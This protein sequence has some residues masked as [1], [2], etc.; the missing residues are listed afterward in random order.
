[1]LVFVLRRQ[2]R[3]AAVIATG[4]AGAVC[5]AFVVYLRQPPEAQSGL[6]ALLSYHSRRPIVTPAVIGSLV[7]G[8]SFGLWI[9]H[10]KCREPLAFLA[11]GCLLLPLLLSNQQIVTDVMISARDW[12]RDVSY[13]LLVFGFLTAASLIFPSRVRSQAFARVAWIAA[14]GCTLIVVRSQFN[15]FRMW[16]KTNLQ[17][18]AIV[19]ALGSVEA[20]LLTEARL[21]FSNAGISQLIQVRMDDRVNVPLTFYKVA[22]RLVPNMAPDARLADP[23]SYENLVFEH[24]LRTGASPERAEDV[25]RAEIRQRAGTFVNYLFSLR[26]ASYPASDNRAFRQVELERS[27]GPIIARYGDYLRLENRRDVLDRPGLLISMESPAEL[28]P[29]PWIRNQFVASGEA[30]GVT[31]YVYRQSAL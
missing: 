11:L 9:L 24:W 15:A 12:E 6:A 29:N 22:T 14:I 18:I 26:D 30:R 23:S 20:P 10:S 7:L 13:S 5:M 1:M 28:S 19:R 17:S 21:T 4:L 16:E 8:S 3:P 27:V 25:L 31:A 2:I